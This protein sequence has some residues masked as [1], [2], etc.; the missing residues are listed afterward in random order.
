MPRVED[1]VSNLK[2]KIKVQE[3]LVENMWGSI[4]NRQVLLVAAIEVLQANEKE[5]KELMVEEPC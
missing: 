1:K 2:A 4:I 5:L 3:Y